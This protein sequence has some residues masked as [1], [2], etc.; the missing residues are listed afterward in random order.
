MTGQAAGI[1]TFAV[2]ANRTTLPGKLCL[3]YTADV[4]AHFNEYPRSLD[5]FRETA[6]D[7]GGH[8]WPGWD[9]TFA[10]EEAWQDFLTAATERLGHKFEELEPVG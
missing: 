1:K 10:S 9:I 7:C 6:R 2:S 8:L 5:A 3:I 4:R